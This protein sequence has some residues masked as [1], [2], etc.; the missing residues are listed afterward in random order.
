M[1]IAVLSIL[2]FFVAVFLLVEFFFSYSSVF[3]VVYAAGYLIV[4]GLIFPSSIVSWIDIGIG[5]LVL[6][7]LIGVSSVLSV[8]A[9]FW[10]VSKSVSGFLGS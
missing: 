3:I 1:I 4:K 9:A 7:T 6:L 8:A 10:L 2:D 5:V